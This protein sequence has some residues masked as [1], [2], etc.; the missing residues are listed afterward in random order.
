MAADHLEV[1]VALGPGHVEALAAL[2]DVE[3]VQA[4]VRT[5]ADGDGPIVVAGEALVVVAA[6]V[7]DHGM[8]EVE[9]AR[10]VD[11]QTLQHVVGRTRLQAVVD[12]RHPRLDHLKAVRLDDHQP[13]TDPAAFDPDLVQMELRAVLDPDPGVQLHVALDQGIVVLVAADHLDIGEAK[14]PGAA[15]LE[16]AQV[17]GALELAQGAVGE[18]PER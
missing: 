8:D 13:R 10:P 17:I 5:A 4:E 11:P 2:R 12:L 16:R 15:D 3:V 9:A 18:P 1:V 14:S 6:Q 7:A